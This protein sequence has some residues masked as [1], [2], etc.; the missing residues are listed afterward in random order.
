[1]KYKIKFSSTA[2]L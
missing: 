2:A 1:M